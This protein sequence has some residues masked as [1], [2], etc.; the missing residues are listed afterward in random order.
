MAECKELHFATGP[1]AH[2]H[3]VFHVLLLKEC[4]KNLMRSECK[5]VLRPVPELVGNYKEYEVETILNKCKL[6]S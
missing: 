4:F 5:Q 3:P 1:S 2:G 6:R